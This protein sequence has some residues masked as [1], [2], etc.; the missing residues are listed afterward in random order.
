MKFEEVLP[1]LRE[2]KKVRRKTWTEGRYITASYGL[3]AVAGDTWMYSE[4]ILDD[5]WEIYKEPVTVADYAV[6]IIGYLW[7]GYQAYYTEPFEVGKEP[8][9]SLKIEGTTREEKR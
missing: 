8:E 1:L 2:G 4:G 9:D 7:D 3:I 6:P 5:D